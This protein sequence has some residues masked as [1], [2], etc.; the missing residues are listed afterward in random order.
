ME[1]LEVNRAF[2]QGKRVF[3]TGH[4]GFKGG[5]LALWLADMG[6]DVY[7]YALTAPTQPSFFDICGLQSRLKASNIAD[8]RDA[9]TLTTA[10]RVAQPEIVLHLAA[11]SLVRLSY[12]APIETFSVNVMGTA[13][14]IEALRGG[15]VASPRIVLASTRAVYGEGAYLDSMGRMVVPPARGPAEMAAGRFAPMLPE[16]PATQPIPTPEAA[17]LH[18][19]SIYAS[20]KLMQEYMLR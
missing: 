13:H 6:A 20:S 4:T 2:W 8:I 19:A 10:K 5:W 11:Q 18:P 9:A 3:L 12:D 1:G 17:A 14:L 15:D 16:G 7:G